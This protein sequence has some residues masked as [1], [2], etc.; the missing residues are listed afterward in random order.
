MLGTTWLRVVESKQKSSM[1]EYIFITAS[2]TILLY[3]LLFS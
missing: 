1:F 2:Y 3:S